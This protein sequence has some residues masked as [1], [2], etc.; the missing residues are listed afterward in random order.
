MPSGP[1]SNCVPHR[2]SRHND[3]LGITG[4]AGVPADRVQGPGQGGA[5][6][7]PPAPPVNDLW[8]VAGTAYLNELTLDDGYHIKVE[9]L[10]DLVEMIDREVAMLERVIHHRLRDDS[11]YK[12]IQAIDGVG[13]VL[14]AVFVAEIGDVSRFSSP[15]AF[16]FVGGIDAQAPRVRHQGPSGPHHQ[17]GIDPGPLGRHRAI[18]GRHGGPKLKAGYHRI[19]ARRGIKIG[20]RWPASSSPSSTSACATARSACGPGPGERSRTQPGREFGYR[21]DPHLGGAVG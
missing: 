9:S 19:G 2:R 12:A 17:A 14:A 13:R 6:Q 4:Q 15:D 11:G 8:G 5:G 18:S 21:H 20:W 1:R 10:R 16:V 3:V 7:P